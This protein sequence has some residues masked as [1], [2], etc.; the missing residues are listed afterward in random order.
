MPLF[1]KN[2]LTKFSHKRIEGFIG[3]LVDVQIQKTP[4]RIRS[5]YHIFYCALSKGFA[6][7]QRQRYDAHAR[8]LV[9]NATITHAVP[10]FGHALHHRRRPGLLFH[11]IFEIALKQRVIFEK[12][13]SARRGIAP[14][15]A[16]CG[17]FPIAIQTQLP[18]SRNIFLI[19]TASRLG[20]N[21]IYLLQSQPINRVVFIDKNSQCIQRGAQQCWWISKM[22]FKLVNFRSLH[23]TRH[24]PE[25]RGAF[26]QRG[27]CCARS[28]ALNLNCYIG[29]VL[30]E[31][32]QPQRHQ[33]IHR[34]GANAVGTSGNSTHFLIRGNR[35]I[36][37]CLS[38]SRYQNS[39]TCNH[40]NKSGH[41]ISLVLCNI[42]YKK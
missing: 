18:P 29:I 12:P 19:L 21:R 7:F 26:N 34:I 17:I 8:C 42:G 37:L 15:K 9:T 14:V 5:I 16:E 31:P 13:I 35:R 30:A 20:K 10:I 33:I 6:S 28:L 2:E 3:R 27:R 24:R 23:R 32:L 4:Q 40:T 39:H 25:L 11:F 41:S 1:G 38:R 36:L 22:L